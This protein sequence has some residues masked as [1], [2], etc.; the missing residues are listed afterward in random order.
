MLPPLPG[1]I[2]TAETAESTSA[3]HIKIA[4]TISAVTL[5]SLNGF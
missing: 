4:K 3:L 1:L 5:K 2:K